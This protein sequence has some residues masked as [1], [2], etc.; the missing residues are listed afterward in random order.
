MTCTATSGEWCNDWYADYGKNRRRNPKGPDRGDY[1]VLRGGSWQHM[2]SLCRA[3]FRLCMETGEYGDY[4]GFRV[5]CDIG[6]RR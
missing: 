4:I 3:A 5:A 1:R 6:G 2:P